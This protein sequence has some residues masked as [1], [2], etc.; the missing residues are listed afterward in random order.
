MSLGR[1]DIATEDIPNMLAP[2]VRACLCKIARQSDTITY[3]ALAKQMELRPPNTIR[4]LT[5]ALEI[6]I[7]EDAAAS[8]PLISALVIS[9][10]RGGLPAPGFFECAARVGR[11]KGDP[12]GPDAVA[13]HRKE[14]ICATAFWRDTAG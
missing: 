2:R 1:T 10:T 12:G 14:L 9:K 11:I 5:V 7:H 4:Q 13:F 3:Q 6:L 8:R